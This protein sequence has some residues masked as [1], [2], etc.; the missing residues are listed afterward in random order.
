MLVKA[1]G[2][3]VFFLRP[4][5]AIEL[6]SR[7]KEGNISL[8]GIDGFALTKSTTQPFLEHSISFDQDRSSYE[9]ARRFLEGYID[10]DLY[11]EVVYAPS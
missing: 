9:K 10:S 7:C 2:G 11:F 8:Y 6:V 4:A 5:D 1:S 3:E